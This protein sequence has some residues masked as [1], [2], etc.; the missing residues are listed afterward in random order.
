MLASFRKEKITN[1]HIISTN[2]R[3]F[4]G[5]STLVT[6]TQYFFFTATKVAVPRTSTSQKALLL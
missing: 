5:L 1:G 6:I 2:N 3:N 4:K